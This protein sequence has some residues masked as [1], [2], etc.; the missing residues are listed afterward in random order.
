MKTCCPNCGAVVDRSA[1]IVIDGKTFCRHCIE[2]EYLPKFSK[3]TPN[4]DDLKK[5]ALIKLVLKT[6]LKDAR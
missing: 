1:L 3:P 6:L 4:S 5:R 2:I